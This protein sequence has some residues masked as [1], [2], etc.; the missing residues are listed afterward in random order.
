VR[1]RLTRAKRELPRSSGRMCVTGEL[2]I[3]AT[4]VPEGETS[5]FRAFSDRCARRESRSST[6]STGGKDYRLQPRGTRRT[7]PQPLSPTPRIPSEGRSQSEPRPRR[8]DPAATRATE[9]ARPNQS[10][11]ASTRSTTSHGGAA[12]G[13]HD[14]DTH[15]SGVRPRHIEWNKREVPYPRRK[16]GSSGTDD[17][18]VAFA[19]ERC[20]TGVDRR[21]VREQHARRP[22]W[23]GRCR[24]SPTRPGPAAHAAALTL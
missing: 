12:R 24:R 14:A 15:C 13:V 19:A 20:T 7:A 21:G 5:T 23:A 6:F 10:F 9:D 16:I 11:S 17:S 22:R 3:A 8:S 4:H 1:G 2:E 18:A